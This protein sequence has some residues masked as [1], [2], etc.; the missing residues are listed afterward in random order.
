MGLRR[1]DN[2]GMRC[3]HCPADLPDG[4]RFCPACGAAA[5]EPEPEAPRDLSITAP[6]VRPGVWNW[7]LA[8]LLVL[9]RLSAWFAFPLDDPWTSYRGWEGAFLWIWGAGLGLLALPLLFLRRRAGGWLAGL[10]G[11]ALL[12]RAAIPLAIEA[13]Y[14][15]Q[16]SELASDSILVTLVFIVASATL[17]FAFFHE[18][19]FWPRNSR[20]DS[21][22]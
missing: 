18:Q 13:P 22:E 11:T 1:S 9:E 21:R 4:A 17:T 12:A 5:P 3:T 2:P 10:S 7:M 16:T 8:I 14:G 15:K 19:S 20:E 6:E